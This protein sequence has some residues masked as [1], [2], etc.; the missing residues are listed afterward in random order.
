[1]EEVT[2]E[3]EKRKEDLRKL[4]AELRTRIAEVNR[5]FKKR[6]ENER[7]EL[8][9]FEESVELS[10]RQ[11]QEQSKSKIKKSKRCFLQVS[12]KLVR[13]SA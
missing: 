13:I 5:K 2:L 7:A 6:E 9:R 1:M 10:I 11:N 12:P 4:D 3:Q 8:E